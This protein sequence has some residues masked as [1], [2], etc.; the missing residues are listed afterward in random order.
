MPPKSQT[1]WEYGIPNAQNKFG[2]AYWRIPN[3]KCR[4]VFQLNQWA[5]RICESDLWSLHYA[6]CLLDRE[7][8]TGVWSTFGICAFGMHK[9][10]WDLGFWIFNL[11]SIYILYNKSIRNF[12]NLS[13]LP[14]LLLQLWKYIKWRLVTYSST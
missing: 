14:I 13:S 1:I 8:S 9:L 7:E 10:I 5:P 6:G 4:S 3:P 11:G 12:Q 2:T